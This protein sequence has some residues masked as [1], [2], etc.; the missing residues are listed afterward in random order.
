MKQREI[1]VTS[2][3][4]TTMIDNDKTIIAMDDT[5]V[6]NI[7]SQSD[8]D[9][10]Q[11]NKPLEKNEDSTSSASKPCS[12]FK[13][14][15]CID[16]TISDEDMQTI[17]NA[18]L[19]SDMKKSLRS[20]SQTLPLQDPSNAKKNASIVKANIQLFNS[21]CSSQ[22]DVSMIQRGDQG[23]T[24]I[25]RESQRET[26]SQSKPLTPTDQVQERGQLHF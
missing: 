20:R 3:K 8:A 25:R 6:R 24:R 16:P 19:K 7:E 10:L 26:R 17:I 14:P 9:K 2:K 18:A 12:V 1:N 22:Q 5:T 23:R 4:D 13:V 15:K 21:F 11:K